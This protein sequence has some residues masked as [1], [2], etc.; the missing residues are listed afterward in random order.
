M[1]LV[2]ILYGAREGCMGR[3]ALWL[4]AGGRARWGEEMGGHLEEGDVL[5]GDVERRRLER[6]QVVGVSA[7]SLGHAGQTNYGRRVWF[8]GPSDGSLC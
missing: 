3:S 1:F 5:A 6:R 8:E 2:L 7:F 4:S